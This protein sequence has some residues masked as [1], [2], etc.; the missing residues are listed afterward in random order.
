MKMSHKLDLL[1][2]NRIGFLNNERLQSGDFVG[3]VILKMLQWVMANEMFGT[4]SLE[5][6]R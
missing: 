2:V 6:C 1:H 5:S 4:T 3:I